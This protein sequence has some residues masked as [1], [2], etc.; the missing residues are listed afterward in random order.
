MEFSSAKEV[1]PLGARYT[2]YPVMETLDPEGACQLRSTSSGLPE[3][4]KG[5]VSVGFADDVLL[6]VNWP[7][8]EPTALGSNVSVTL[9]VCPGLSVAGRL[10]ADA[11]KPL[12]VTAMELTVTAA[13]PLEVKVTVCV[14]ELFTATPPNAM[15]VAF[16]VS[17]GVPAFS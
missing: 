10:T 2:L 9:T 7:V 16:T 3:P 1:A 11:E 17:A 15:L 12:P 8:A 5:T 4:L 13:V 6:M 14:V